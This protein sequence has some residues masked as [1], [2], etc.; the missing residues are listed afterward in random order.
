VFVGAVPPYPPPMD[1]WEDENMGEWGEWKNI[2]L[3]QLTTDN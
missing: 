3:Q 2:F 1:R